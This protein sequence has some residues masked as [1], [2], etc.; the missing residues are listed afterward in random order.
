[1]NM[2]MVYDWAVWIYE[3]SGEAMVSSGTV[4]T[5]FYQAFSKWKIHHPCDLR[6]NIADIPKI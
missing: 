6:F 1:M 2:M 3:Q 5:S 4:G